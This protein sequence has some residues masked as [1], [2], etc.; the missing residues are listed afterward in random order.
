MT[1]LHGGL[2]SL[3][4]LNSDAR[5][6]QRIE[7]IEQGPSTGSLT[8]CGLPCPI[9]RT[10]AT[11]VV[12]TNTHTRSLRWTVAADGSHTGMEQRRALVA[13]LHTG[14]WSLRA[15]AR[16]V[17]ATHPE[18]VRRDLVAVAAT[19][20]GVTVVT[21]APDRVRGR[22][23]KSYPAVR[24]RPGVPAVPAKMA[25][26]RLPSALMSSMSPEW[27]SPP[28]VVDPVLGF[29]GVIDLD[30]CADPGR[31]I[32]ATMHFTMADDG[33][34]HEWHGR[35]FMNPPYGHGIGVWMSK[36]AAEFASGRVT[37]AIA[38]VPARVDT[39]WWRDFPARSVC[40]VDGRLKFSG[41]K[42]SAPFPS[43]LLY[44]GSRPEVFEA[45]FSPLG[46]IYRQREAV[47]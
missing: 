17:G 46:R 24:L 29:L 43:A 16:V 40:F 3:N 26:R 42:T 28:Q 38:L 37:E 19:A 13:A 9:K 36:L 4:S 31:A 41:A 7:R 14:G 45:A 1:D 25:A 23:G 11:A 6:E 20:T 8:P 10:P 15:I 12:D 27:Y 30:P 5:V 39:H 22:D 32:P 47:A 35:I 2:K 18:Q 44:L 34:A 33:L 21:P